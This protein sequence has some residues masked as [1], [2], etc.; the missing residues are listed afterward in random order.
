MDPI[1]AR[2]LERVLN[3]L[4]GGECGSPEYDASVAVIYEEP[5]RSIVLVERVERPGDPWSGH[6]AFPGGFRKP[7]EDSYETAV[8][9]AWEEIHVDLRRAFHLGDIG[10]WI[11]RGSTRVIPHIFISRETL[12]PSPGEEVARVIKVGI[13]YIERVECPKD[14]SRP[15]CFRTPYTGDKVIWGLTAR[16]IEWLMMHERSE[17]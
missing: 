15:P 10:I 5:S 17:G 3:P 6:I 14:I 7:G 13:S 8:R 1:L 9:E 16:I 12:E 2:I 4:E 11:T